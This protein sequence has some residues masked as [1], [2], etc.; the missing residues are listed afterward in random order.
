MA[1]SG[2][3]RVLEFVP[4][5]STGM[6]AT[7]ELGAPPAAAFTSSTNQCI[8]AISAN[9][10]CYPTAVA[11]DAR[12]NLWV[13]DTQNQRVLEFAPPF[14]SG[15]AAALVIGHSDF[16][17]KVAEGE[18]IPAPA[19]DNM[20]WPQGMSFDR[21]GNLLVQDQVYNRVL[22][23]TPPFSSGM[24]ATAVLGQ[25]NMASGGQDQCGAGCSWPTP[26]AS[27]LWNPFGA[28]AY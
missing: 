27:T 18:G 4:P 3:S 21:Y 26:T 19:A 20:F 10:M 14:T 8:G 17:Q 13:A 1:D 12:G 5:F 28:V 7:V 15:E 24:S 23:F 6:S 9:S 25:P 22:V 16:A 11:F 2:N